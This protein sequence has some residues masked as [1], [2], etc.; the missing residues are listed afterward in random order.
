MRIAKGMGLLLVLFTFFGCGRAV[1]R[2]SI[3]VKVQS[4][5]DI[6]RYANLAVLPF[7]SERQGE[8]DEEI[9]PE[10][11]EE[12][13][14]MLRRGLA[15]QEHFQVVDGQ[16]TAR[17]LIGDTV[18][19]EWLT[20]TKH[21]SQLGDYFEVKAVIIGSF[22]FDAD[23]RPRRYYGERYSVQ[24]QRYVLG[25]QD[26]MQ[27]TYFLTLRVLIVDV[28][29]GKVIWDEA[30]RRTTAEAHTLGSFIFSQAGPQT[31]TI[32]ELGKRAVA[33]FTRQISPHYEKE[34]RYLVN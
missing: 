26:Y 24:Q 19:P 7:V 28:E 11:G 32:R 5:I 12:I 30:Y 14:A 6:A 9:P 20:D 22:R 17:L 4:E 15:R 31:N 23:S 13:A 8:R 16:E 29:T 27:K 25:Y 1:T 34:D 3:P 21:L 18:T 2:V 10:I 33:E